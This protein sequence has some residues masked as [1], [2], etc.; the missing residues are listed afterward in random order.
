MESLRYLNKGI[1]NNERA[2]FDNWWY[3]QIS[4]YGQDIKYYHNQSSLSA[5]NVLYG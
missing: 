1:N 5:M 4:I 2:N 3:E